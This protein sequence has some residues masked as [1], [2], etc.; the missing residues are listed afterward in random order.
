MARKI[1]E[2]FCTLMLLLQAL[3]YLLVQY[4]IINSWFFPATVIFILT[5][6]LGGI[7]ALSGVGLLIKQRGGDKPARPEAIMVFL[8]CMFSVVW[9]QVFYGWQFIFDLTAGNDY[10]TDIADVPQFQQSKHERLIVKEV[11][12]I[13]G[14][15]DIPHV[16]LKADIDTIFLPLSGLE[17][18]VIVKRAINKLGWRL[19]RY[20]D[21]TSAVDGFNQ[22]YEI[23]GGNGGVN[24]LT[25]LV[26]RIVSDN[27]ESSAV[28]IRS[29]SPGRRRDLGFNQHMIQK[30]A[31]ELA[32][33]LQNSSM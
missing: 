21:N 23:V 11:S 15:M 28:D 12:P 25:D 31:E 32:V 17:S 19:V 26:V 4:G 13:W 24:Q 16:I 29:S 30:F 14:F 8:M 7:G 18:K 33:L 20:S 6:I 2:V 10:T 1:I 22:T 5:I 3:C 9:V 27:A